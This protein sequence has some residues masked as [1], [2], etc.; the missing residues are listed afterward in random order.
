MK[1][2]DNES[3]PKTKPILEDKPKDIAEEMKPM[4]KAKVEEIPDEDE[5][6]NSTTNIL[7]EEKNSILAELRDEAWINKTNVATEL[8]IKENER[9]PTRSWFPR[10]IMNT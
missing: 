3:K 6:K 8:A 2:F 4:L 9:K 1:K 5:D 7:E 10:N